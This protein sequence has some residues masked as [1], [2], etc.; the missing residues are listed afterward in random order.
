MPKHLRVLAHIC[1]TCGLVGFGASLAVLAVALNFGIE[2]TTETFGFNA[3]MA[4][5]VASYAVPSLVAGLGLK[6]GKS[7]APQVVLVL[8]VLLVSMV[9]IGTALSLYALWVILGQRGLHGDGTASALAGMGQLQRSIARVGILVVVMTGVWAGYY[10]LLHFGF[11][12]AVQRA[13]KEVAAVLPNAFAVLGV[14]AMMMLSGV[15]GSI[16][17]MDGGVLHGGRAEMLGRR[18]RTGWWRLNDFERNVHPAPRA[19]SI[20]GSVKEVTFPDHEAVLAKAGSAPT[21]CGH[22][23]PIEQAITEAGLTITHR[24]ELNV[25]AECRVNPYALSHQLGVLALALYYERHMIDRSFYDPM[26]AFF[27]CE[28]CHSHIHVVH[29]DEASADTPWFPK[30]PALDRSIASRRKAANDEG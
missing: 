13:P 28:A 14:I 2:W 5:V 27:Y 3:P 8:S 26:Q 29:P 30:P 24:G 20:P 7:W 10:V 6:H 12:L 4:L 19:S 16:R 15:W 11:L 1:I 25:A 17:G 18:H 9:P 22:L 23:R 21:T